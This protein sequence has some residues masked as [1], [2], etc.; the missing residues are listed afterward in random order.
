MKP[1]KDRVDFSLNP[2]ARYLFYEEIKLRPLSGDYIHTRRRPL[3]LPRRT[4]LAG[5]NC[6]ATTS[7]LFARTL[8]SFALAECEIPGLHM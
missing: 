2:D 3:G 8:L 7:Y 6:D 4:T 1:Q 5:G